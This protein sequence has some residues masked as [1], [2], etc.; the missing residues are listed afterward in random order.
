[1]YLCKDCGSLIKDLKHFREYHGQPNL[2]P[3]EWN[4]CPACGSRACIEA[5]A[6]DK[7]S[8]YISNHCIVTVDGEVICDNCYSD[9]YIEDY[10]YGG[11]G[12]IW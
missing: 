10:T 3:E 8:E 11:W 4:G 7:C 5:I 1:M 6:C 12:K 2:Q 9:Y